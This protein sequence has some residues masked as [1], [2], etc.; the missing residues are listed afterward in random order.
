MT[1]PKYCIAKEGQ[2]NDWKPVLGLFCPDCADPDS[3]NQT[4]SQRFELHPAGGGNSGEG[5]YMLSGQSLL[6]LALPRITILQESPGTDLTKNHS[7]LFHK[8]R[9]LAIASV[10]QYKW[11]TGSKSHT[12]AVMSSAFKQGFRQAKGTYRDTA[13]IPYTRLVSVSNKKGEDFS[14]SMMS[15]AQYD[16]YRQKTQVSVNLPMKCILASLMVRSSRPT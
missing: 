11:P 10:L 9:R 5:P 13:G 15:K 3:T 4:A 16:L 2:E 12:A 7:D 8:D 1:Y 14:I 6:G